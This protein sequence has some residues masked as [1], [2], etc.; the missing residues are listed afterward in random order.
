MVFF[1]EK[2][3]IDFNPDVYKKLGARLIKITQAKPFSV[4]QVLKHANNAT[5]KSI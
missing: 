4:H 3:T 1:D 5:E 2:E